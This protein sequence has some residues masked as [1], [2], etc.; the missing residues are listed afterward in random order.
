MQAVLNEPR[1]AN[2]E[3]TWDC[4][5]FV[6]SIKDRLEPSVRQANKPEGLYGEPTQ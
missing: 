3:T 5:L 2:V 1:L 6:S 4:Y